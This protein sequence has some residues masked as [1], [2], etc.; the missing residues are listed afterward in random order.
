ML[1]LT[2]YY[3]KN[4][5]TTDFF[6]D[7]LV[8][9]KI[10]FFMIMLPLDPG[11]KIKVYQSKESVSCIKQIGS[12]N[13]FI[14]AQIWNFIYIF[15]AIFSKRK[16]IT[17]YIGFG[18]VTLLPA[19]LLKRFGLRR[20]IVF[21]GVDFS[22]KRFS[23]EL[24]NNIYRIIEKIVVRGAD[25]TIS[26]TKRAEDERIKL[27]LKKDRSLVISNGVNT[28]LLSQ[29]QG[30]DFSRDL[31]LIFWGSITE[32]SGLLKFIKENEQ[33][34]QKVSLDIIGDGPLKSRILALIKDMPKISFL[35]SMDLKSIGNYINKLKCPCF[36]I[37]PYDSK[38]NDHVYFGDSLKIK[39]YLLFD[40][41][42]IVSSDGYLSEDIKEFGFAYK[43]SKE[44][45]EFLNKGKVFCRQFVQSR[46]KRINILNKYSWDNLFND[47]MEKIG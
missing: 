38:H 42:Y 33:V 17:S 47:L 35:G 1:F 8:A 24:L 40:L 30:I 11:N 22:Q 25:L 43:S 32:Q 37:A 26:V 36:G 10:P 18:S 39:E 3:S 14:F 5:G 20:K 15:T 7:Y 45:T 19:L 12:P 16:E 28:E 31:H 9:R 44:L 13:H 23:S 27:G 34:L 2:S 4:K 46:E 41:P 21:Y 29:R 6:T